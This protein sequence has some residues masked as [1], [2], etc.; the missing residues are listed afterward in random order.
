MQKLDSA[1]SQYLRHSKVGQSADGVSLSQSWS[2]VVGE[3]MAQVSHPV[4]LR[5]GVLTVSVNHPAFVQV[6][7]FKRVALLK[8]IHESCPALDIQDFRFQVRAQ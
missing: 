8:T 7:G 5:S 2:S 3:Q 4:S 1:L 6:L